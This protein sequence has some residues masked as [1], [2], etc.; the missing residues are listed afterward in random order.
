MR[1]AASIANVSG[2]RGVPAPTLMRRWLKA[3]LQGRRARAELGVR[4]VD[5]AE[6]AALNARYRQRAG[7]TNVLS[8]PAE[9]PADVPVPLLGDLVL[10]APV[11][12]REAAEQGKPAA[13]HW[14]H[15]LVHGVLHLLGYDHVVAA[16]AE[17]MEAEET[18]VLVA[19][20]FSPPYNPPGDHQTPRP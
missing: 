3:A 10:C 16:D 14:A 8:F 20:G 5:E 1:L 13:A 15:L 9:L 19:M 2:I 11:V 7:A 6:G 12:I 18:A 17:I 4:I